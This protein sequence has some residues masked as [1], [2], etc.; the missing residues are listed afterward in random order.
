MSVCENHAK[1][2]DP[3]IP[4]GFLFHFVFYSVLQE[5]KPKAAVKVPET[6]KLPEKAK[7]E[8]T[9]APQAEAQPGIMEAEPWKECVFTLPHPSLAHSF[10]Y[11]PE[12]TEP[13]PEVATKKATQ[14]KPAVKVH[15]PPETGRS[16]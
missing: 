11:M 10:V 14:E 15:T 8:K 7:Q 5:S 16:V 1:L 9:V 13:I 12:V 4:E 2:Q 3:I 6:E